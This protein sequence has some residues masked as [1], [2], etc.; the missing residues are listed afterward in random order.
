MAIK[1]Q[2]VANVN[3]RKKM[4]FFAPIVKSS[5]NIKVA[6]ILTENNESSLPSFGKC[7]RFSTRSA[8]VSRIWVIQ[9]LSPAFFKCFH[10]KVPPVQVSCLLSEYN[11]F[12]QGMWWLQPPFPS[13]RKYFDKEYKKNLCVYCSFK[14]V[15]EKP[16][17]EFFRKFVFSLYTCKAPFFH[18]KL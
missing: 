15:K 10:A 11:R 7:Q 3:D 8:K 5:I 18:V 17:K 2:S 4:I 14:A 9:F 1:F 16:T 12:K 13:D 6:A